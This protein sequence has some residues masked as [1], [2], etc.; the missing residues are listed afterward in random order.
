MRAGWYRLRALKTN[1]SC[2]VPG[3]AAEGMAVPLAAKELRPLTRR[4]RRP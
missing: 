1:S 3:C 4:L 2:Q